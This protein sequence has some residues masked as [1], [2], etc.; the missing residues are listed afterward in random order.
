MLR[1]V[2]NVG[3]REDILDAVAPMLGRSDEGTF[4]VMDVVMEM[5]RRGSTYSES[6]IRTHVTSRM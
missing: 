1:E 5:Q 2:L 3:C 6:T 4:G